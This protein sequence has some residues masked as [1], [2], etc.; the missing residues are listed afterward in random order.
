[1]ITLTKSYSNLCTLEEED[2][3]Y[4]QVKLED[5]EQDHKISHQIDTKADKSLYKDSVYEEKEIVDEI[6]KEL[7][8]L[9][10]GSLREEQM[11]QL[12]NLK[13]I[14]SKITTSIFQ[15]AIVIYNTPNGQQV[16]LD[17]RQPLVL[18]R[19]CYRNFSL[20]WDEHK[21]LIGIS[22]TIEEAL[23]RCNE[24]FTQFL[25]IN[26]SNDYTLE[27][28]IVYCTDLLDTISDLYTLTRDSVSHLYDFWR[29]VC[30]SRHPKASTCTTIHD[31]PVKGTHWL[32]HFLGTYS[33][34]GGPLPTT[35]TK[36]LH[37][38]KDNWKRV[39]A[40]DTHTICEIIESR[41]G[42]KCLTDI[43]AN[44][45]DWLYTNYEILPP[46][47]KM[48]IA[49]TIQQVETTQLDTTQLDTSNVPN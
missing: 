36:L 21:T 3:D 46:H 17:Y 27:E 25:H 31:D 22:H 5:Y 38:W 47:L 45:E 32:H 9:S 37:Y 7:Q 11:K 34:Y 12:D 29:R 48:L 14:M 19:T 44:F 28:K 8:E 26:R 23:Q 39:I 15:T 4:L 43:C 30:S 41:F 42:N 2:E 1:M 40:E 10:M 16:Q 6:T 20:R 18:W 49:N 35:P 13:D 33:A 24:S